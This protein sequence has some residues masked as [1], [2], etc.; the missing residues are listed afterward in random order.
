PRFS[1][2]AS[3]NEMALGN[4]IPFEKVIVSSENIGKPFLVRISLSQNENQLFPRRQASGPGIGEVVTRQIGVGT[5]YE[6]L[7]LAGHIA[8]VGWRG[9]YQNIGFKNRFQNL[10]QIVFKHASIEFCLACHAALT[11]L[12]LELIQG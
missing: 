2:P 11:T 7:Q 9:Q 10:G 8:I 5:V 1:N 4:S 12:V 3:P 6:T